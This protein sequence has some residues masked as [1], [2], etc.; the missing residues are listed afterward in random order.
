[1]VGNSPH[2]PSSHASR[3]WL[4]HL[5][6]RALGLGA[7]NGL[8]CLAPLGISSLRLALAPVNH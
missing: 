4:S 6:G 1:M 3:M 2:L 7:R 5:G 8:A